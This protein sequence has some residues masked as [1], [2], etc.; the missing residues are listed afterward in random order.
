M[1]TQVSARLR[2][3]DIRSALRP[4]LLGQFDG[5][6]VPLVVEELGICRGQARADMAVVNGELHGFEI[7][8]DRDS[9]RRLRNQVA[10]Y[11][12]VFGR[13][14]L[15]VG[16]CIRPAIRTA[17]P[18]WW[19]ILKAERSAT[20]LH[21]RSVRKARANPRRDVRTLAEFLWL[22]DAMRLL[23]ERGAARGV[24][25]KP[26]QYVWDRLCAHYGLHELDFAVRCHLKARAERRGP[27]QLT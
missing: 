7:K 13:A 1:A 18:A 12:K 10:F 25:G 20:G 17:I 9:P 19:G 22:A 6:D 4:Y 11:G 3:A 8:S 5:A 15:V 21:F 2:D 16:E 14:T 26:R 27:P 24:R 23:E